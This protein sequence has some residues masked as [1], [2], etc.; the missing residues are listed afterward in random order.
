[1]EELIAGQQALKD[2]LDETAG[3]ITDTAAD[4]STYHSQLGQMAEDSVQ[5]IASVQ[6]DYEENLQA[7]LEETFPNPGRYR[8]L[9]GKDD[10]KTG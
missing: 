5:Q 1:M 3:K 8:H 7:E 6:S 10:G 2:K 9:R 4:I